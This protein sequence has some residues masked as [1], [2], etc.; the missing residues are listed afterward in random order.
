MTVAV[1]P[2]EFTSRRE[3]R[4][5]CALCRSRCGS[6][7]IVE[8][9]RL[10]EV[11]PDP[12]HPTGGALCPKG[13]A[14]PEIVHSDRR[15][16]T[17]L[18]RTRPKGDPDP[19]WQEIGWDEALDQV[20]RHMDEARREIGP[21]AV[22]FAVT[23]PSGTAMSDSIDW[24]ERF[25]RLFGS[26]NNVY[27]VEVCNWH[28]D[29]AHAFT[30][31]CGIPVAQYRDAGLIML[32]GHN[33]SNVWLAQA[34]AVAEGRRR[35]AKVIVVD[36]RR[37]AHVAGAD[38]WL[39]V[40]PGTDAALALGL[41]RLL[42]EEGRYDP[43]FVREWTNAPLLV[44][45]DNG[46]FLR[47]RDLAQSLIRNSP[48][49]HP[50]VLGEAE[51]RRTQ[52]GG[53]SFEAGLRPAPQDEERGDYD[54]LSGS[55]D[56]GV[57]GE[58]Y[59][60]WNVQVGAPVALDTRFAT[61][62]A[63][64]LALEGSFTVE[65][66]QGP[67]ACRPAFAH[68]AEAC[69]PYDPQTVERI[70]GVAA[71]DLARAADLIVEA[72]NDIAYH[73]WTGV[74][75]HANATQTERAMA[76]LYALTGAFD[77]P[78]GNLRMTK[79]PANPLTS[80]AQ[81]PAAQRDK[82][83]G[84][85]RLPLGPPSMAWTIGSD[86]YASILDEKPYP[87]RVLVAFG[88]NLLLSQPD[89]GRAAA[90]L[91]KLSFHV[92]CDLFHS[93]TSAYADIILPVSTTWEREALK[94]G[95]E[96]TQEAEEVVALRPAAIPPVGEARSDI[97]IVLG[98]ATRLGMGNEFFG[99]SLEA[100]WDHVLEPLGL[101]AEALRKSGGRARY[102]L[103]AE[104][105]KHAAPAPGGVAPGAV[106]GFDTETR[107]AELYSALLKRHG[108]SP[109]PIHVEPTVG[110]AAPSNFPLTLVSA[111]LGHFCHSQHRG[112]S[113]LRRRSL[114][115][116]AELHPDLAAARGVAE[117]DWIRIAT[118]VGEARFRTRLAP[119]L[120][121]DVVVAQHGWWEGCADLGLPGYD[122]LR[123]TGSNFNALIGPEAAARD[124]ISGAPAQRSFA[125]E[126]SRDARIAAGWT[127]FAHLRV[128]AVEPESDGAVSLVLEARD[129]GPLPPFRPGQHLPL[130][131][132]TRRPGDDAPLIR[133]YSLS[134]PA[135]GDAASR[136]RVT[137]KRIEADALREIAPGRVST[138]LTRHVRPGDTVEAK[139]PAG[140][141]LP[142]LEA[143]FPVVLIAAGIGIT[144][145]KSYLETLAR[146]LGRPEVLLLYGSRDGA[147][148]VFR[149][150]LAA[151]AA[152]MPEVTIVNAYSR[153]APGDRQGIDFDVAGRISAELVPQELIDRRA[154]FY[155]CGPDAMMRTVSAE[156]VRRG[157]YR[158]E[159]LRE[160]F[161]AGAGEIVQGAHVAHQVRFLRSGR[162]A[163]WTPSAGTLLDLADRLGLDLPAGCRVGQ[164][165]SCLVPLVSGN[166]ALLADTEV[167][168]S[169][170]L[171][172]RSVPT[173]DV[174]LDA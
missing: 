150:E 149:R 85:D 107:R 106:R 95:F 159:I 163:T 93:P 28:K 16:L 58:A 89:S 45:G 42:I 108:Y 168:S 116:V 143:A 169:G 44:R 64:H 153:P 2:A 62:G 87:V 139:V 128:A 70:T 32:W 51:P 97:A 136:Y 78:R 24:V 27:G 109:V 104:P 114:D 60:A 158:F 3:V 160:V 5:W 113:S 98:L 129:G 94:L 15:I 38:L 144:P 102:P 54:P 86:L 140:A 14:G 7:S 56:G 166:V 66:P 55:Q 101:T 172:C 147:S 167:E 50:E 9:G 96:I 26:P 79:L 84:L 155:L 20:A 110:D 142:P 67:L 77:T 131:V 171:T 4:G 61:G 118:R 135:E 90:A 35:G 31:G 92:H 30:F 69:R 1:K 123:G 120:R 105:R 76:T 133:S 72:G 43:A 154:R 152:A 53:A 25:I 33:P 49:P 148:H 82:A 83:L 63:D 119:S 127:G 37:S 174:V 99:G 11:R 165:E 17:P 164:C 21:E 47:G 68:F 126:V 48:H 141:F 8:D 18:R 124:P 162:E 100:G 161:G 132:Q 39:Q 91:E 80:L 73:G 46:E 59:V 125:C 156:L 23:T 13:R 134:G 117:G 138:E 12:D 103:R 65:T 157:A 71:A 34:G 74:G 29:H 57:P 170:C 146:R 137:V 115:P 121:P 40:R 75:Q 19:G 151:L 130:R 6:I 22:G 112:V 10:I 52:D 122:P 145:F 41:S 36:P 88:S 81:L 173:S 111:K